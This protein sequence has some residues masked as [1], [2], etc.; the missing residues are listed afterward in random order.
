ME[1]DLKSSSDR[2]YTDEVVIL[3]PPFKTFY[4]APKMPQCQKPI[5]KLLEYKFQISRILRLLYINSIVRP[6][7]SS[8]T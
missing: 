8:L 2:L 7:K 4:I 6:S 5:P 1:I 3:T